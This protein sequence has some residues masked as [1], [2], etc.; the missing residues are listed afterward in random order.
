MEVNQFAAL[1]IARYEIRLRARAQATLPPFLGSTLRGA[2]GHALKDVVCRIEHRDCTRCMVASCCPFA[3]LFETAAAADAPPLRG[4]RAPHPF[5]LTPPELLQ[6]YDREA[7]VA[8]AGLPQLAEERTMPVVTSAAPA[9]PKMMPVLRKAGAR[10]A[11]NAAPNGGAQVSSGRLQGKNGDLLNRSVS[12]RLS[13]AAGDEL[14]FHL[15]LLGRA[16]E[17]LPYIVHA[18]NRMAAR[19]LGAE[20]V[21]FSLSQVSLLDR[22][23]AR[24][25]IYKA[26]DSRVL[27]PADAAHR[28]SDLLRERLHSFR[29]QTAGDGGKDDAAAGLNRN[30]VRLRFT[31]P[32]RIRVEGDLQ[33]SLSFALLVRS[34]LRRVSLLS[35][36][37]GS[38]KL[39]LDY[40]GLIARAAQVS[41]GESWLRWHDWERYSNR[42]ETKMKLGGFLG[43]VEYGGAAVR[44]FLPLLFAGEL[45]HVG[46]GTSFGLG[47][48]YVAE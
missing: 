15:T 35:E 37:H 11:P 42:Q 29:R 34:L 33:T 41:V 19:G 8:D 17:Y 46:A 32:T 39:E 6:P 23:G 3:Y 36:L 4:Q 45:L 14:R 30:L 2:F 44:D 16:A 5:I 26:D 40:R 18:I 27:V 24:R 43:E 10:A 21:R 25:T 13:L 22:E 9:L 20:R 7:P 48:F 31:T 47:K 38:S 1:E 28:L 12:E